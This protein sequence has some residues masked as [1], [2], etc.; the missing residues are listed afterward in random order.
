M[1]SIYPLMVV[2][3][4][5]CNM[6]TKTYLLIFIVAQ[7]YSC[8]A[9]KVVSYYDE[10]IDFS[11]FETFDIVAETDVVAKNTE[12]TDKIEAEILNEMEARGYRFSENADMNVQYRII[13]EAKTNV[14]T[15]RRTTSY[16]GRRYRYYQTEVNRYSQG[17]LLVEITNARSHK[18]L[19]SGSLDLS[20]NQRSR[21]KKDIGGLIEMVFSKFPVGKKE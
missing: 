6:K 13:L 8:A 7:L 3:L 2:E 19:W 15:D 4:L 5:L 9:P 17:I 14:Q 16:Y 12:E 1:V 18:L 20:F 10:N 11:E 21:E